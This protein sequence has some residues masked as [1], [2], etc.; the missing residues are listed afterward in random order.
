[1]I[2]LLILL[3]LVTFTACTP[4]GERP[5]GPVNA[6]NNKYL[7]RYVDTEFKVVCYRVNGHTEMSC[8]DYK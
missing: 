8:T 5:I 2:K 6:G 3:F 4:E 1:M 7:T